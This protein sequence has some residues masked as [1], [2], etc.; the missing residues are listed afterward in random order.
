MAFALFSFYFFLNVGLKNYYAFL[1]SLGVSIL[2][3]PSI[4][5]PFIDHHSVIFSIMAAYSMSLAILLQKNLFWLLTPIFLIISFL[6]KQI[7]SSYLILLF[8]ITFSYLYFTKNING[9]NLLFLLLGILFSFLTVTAIFLVNEIPL[10]NFMIQ[11][12]FYPVSLGEQRIDKLEINFNN[13]INQF[14]FIYLSLIPFAMSLFI[15]KKKEKKEFIFSV[16]FL[17]VTAIIIYCQLLTRNQVLIFSLIPIS[18]ALSHAYTLKYFDKKY[19]IYFILIV[20]IFS[21]TKYHI[22]FNHNKKFIE[23]INANFNLAQDPTRLDKRLRGLKWITPNYTDKPKDEIDLLIDTKNIL[24]EQK[25]RK[26][27]VSDYQFFSSL[28]NNKFASPNKWYDDLSVPNKENKYYNNYRD[29]FLSKI[30]NNKIKHI[31][32][33]GEDKHVMD[34]FIELKNI[35]ECIVSNKINELLVEFDMSE[36]SKIL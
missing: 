22:R 14:K 32:F 8:I 19:L 17:G 16:F 25:G 11:Y 18:A 31:Y 4:G 20:F 21:T 33:I 36:C 7:P 15:S 13:L 34:F 3:Y 10:K 2:A 23:L 6:S 12:I 9:K 35:N 26:V 1:Y 29:F 24:T 5:T 27:I 28:L 30:N